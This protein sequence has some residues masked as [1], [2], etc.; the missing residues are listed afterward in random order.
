VALVVVLGL[1]FSAGCATAPRGEAE[2]NWMEYL[3]IQ[4]SIESEGAPFTAGSEE[5][6]RSVERFQNA[7]SDFKAPDFGERIREVYAGDAFFNDTLKTVR[8]V[9]AI[10]DYLMATAEA[11]DH[12]RVEFLNVV[13]ANGNYYFRWAMTIR[14]KHFARGEDQRSV[15]MTHVRFNS[16]GKVLLHQDFWDSTGGLFEHVPMLGWMLRRAKKRL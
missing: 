8:G 10:Q 2:V 15:G 7:L 13:S 9:D 6:R 3:E 5:E 14:F 16:E 12:G 4:H 1:S 11:I